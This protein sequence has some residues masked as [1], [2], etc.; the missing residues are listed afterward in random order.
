MT[1]S[2]ESQFLGRYDFHLFYLKA[3]ASK[4]DGR[5]AGIGLG[6]HPRFLFEFIVPSPVVV[7]SK[8]MISIDSITFVLSSE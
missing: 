3:I 2:D 7:Y 5:G 6:T 4:E 1:V 8:F